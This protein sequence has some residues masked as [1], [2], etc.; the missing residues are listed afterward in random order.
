MSAKYQPVKF[1]IITFLIT[2]ISWF[3]AA[4]FSFQPDGE[5]IYI[6]FLIPGLVA[7]FGTALIMM[8]SA[9]DKSL[10]QNFKTKLFNLR[11]I[12]LS[13]LPIILFLMPAVV[14]F[15]I[16]ISIPFGQPASQLAFSPDFSFSV[17][18]YRSC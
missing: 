15:S 8:L 18:L 10:W 7:P 5:S 11:L 17:G 16:L 6:L 3:I 14:C 2:W 4:W 1:F 13:S 12:R 9:K